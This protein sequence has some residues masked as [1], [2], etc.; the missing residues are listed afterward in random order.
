MEDFELIKLLG[1]GGFGKTFH[2]RVVDE[3]TAEYLGAPE[4]AR[5]IPSS[6]K[7]ELALRKEIETN[8]AVWF[9]LRQL[10]D[11]NLVRY[12]GQ[13]TYNGQFVMAMELM[14]GSLR[15]TLKAAKRKGTRDGAA[16]GVR[17][18]SDVLHGL[19]IL[20][21]QKVFHRDLKPEN[22]LIS[23]TGAAKVADFGLSRLLASEDLA[24]SRV[25]TYWYMSPEILSREGAS[26]TSDI[27]ALGVTLYE[28]VTGQ[29]PFGDY[30]STAIRP[31]IE[32]ICARPHAP[33]HTACPEV[34]IALSRVIDVALSKE[35]RDRFHTA[36][37]MLG[38]LEHAVGG[39]PAGPGGQAPPPRKEVPVSAGRALGFDHEYVAIQDVVNRIG[40]T[41][42]VE[43]KLRDL[44]AKFPRE[45]KA[46]RALAE[47]YSKCH[48]HADAADVLT[49]G[50]AVDPKSA[51]M[52]FALAM[53]L[54]SLRQK[55]EAA[56]AF[57]RAI[58]LGLDANR[59]KNART[60]LR[61]L[62]A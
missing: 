3:D 6:K 19:A 56:V 8:A 40:Q 7:A 4:V 46:Y 13:G 34:P 41:Q 49:R 29:L 18:M 60:M 53:A 38:A 2:A 25:G 58:E 37:E 22:I 55:S 23:R 21:E 54:N 44:V 59:D 26:F 42:A 1:E 31:L 15:G 33:A 9:H 43:E 28:L 5:K 48:R 16:A 14:S 52:H 39:P 12:L 10:A 32:M 61:A 57:R 11:V 35:P 62:G 36:E 45:P 51:D 30:T 17:L 20:H 47:H 27:W 24:V 50:T